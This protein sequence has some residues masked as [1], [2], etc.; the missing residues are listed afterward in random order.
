[1]LFEKSLITG[2]FCFENSNEIFEN[3]HRSFKFVV[4][5][6]KKGEVTKYFPARFMRHDVAELER[7]PANDEILISVGLV[8]KLSPDSLSIMEFKNE[9]DIKIAKKMLKWPLLSEDVEGKWK[10]SLSAEFHMTNDSYLFKTEPGKGRLPLYE[11]KMIWQFESKYSEPRYWIDEKQ[12]RKALCGKEAD[13]KEFFDYQNIRLGFRDV[14]ANTNERTLIASLIPGNCFAGNTLVFAKEPVNRKILLFIVAIFD[15]F[16]IDSMI[17]QK[18]TNHCNFF[19]MFQLPVPRLTHGDKWFDEI[20]SRAA[21]LICT[22]PE[23]DELWDEVSKTIDLTSGPSSAGR[24]EKAG[25]GVTD[26]VERAKLRA[27]LDGMIAHLYELTEEE[28]SYI[29]TTFPLVPEPVKLAARNAYRDVER[30]LIK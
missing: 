3:V 30:G 23:F 25:K 10:L 4:L 28:F 27:E 24:G 7:F 8:K 29:L 6:Y 20:V 11:G 17:R 26:P 22:T 12:G 9:M 13:S 14:T 1:M 15:S 16:C 21:R 2:L 18:I 5:T 19:Y